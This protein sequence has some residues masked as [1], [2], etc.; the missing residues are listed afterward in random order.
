MKY[1]LIASIIF[2]SGL[3]QLLNACGEGGIG[4]TGI[5]LSGRINSFGSI[6]VNGIEFNTD[7]ATLVRDN[8]LASRQSDFAVGEVVTVTGYINTNKK[9]GVANKVVFS[10][11]I[12]GPVTAKP[13]LLADNFMVM[14]QTIRINDLTVLHGFLTLNDLNPADIVEISGF[15]DSSGIIQASSITLKNA[16]ISNFEIKGIFFMPI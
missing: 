1:R 10:D 11:L 14:G 15:V 12:E 6:I 4:G 9:T 5:T 16:A 7:N 13:A 2:F 8:S 3:L